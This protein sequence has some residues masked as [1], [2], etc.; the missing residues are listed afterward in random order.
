MILTFQFWFESVKS[1]K[2]MHIRS[3]GS[4]F[5]P[6][7]SVKFHSTPRKI[8]KLVIKILYIVFS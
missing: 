2:R 5:L 3:R 7:Y 6:L 4:G 8:I 1:S